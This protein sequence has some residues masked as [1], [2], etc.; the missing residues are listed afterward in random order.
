MADFLQTIGL[1]D[2]AFSRGIKRVVIN[3]R[4][5]GRD[6]TRAF[7]DA[8]KKLR[9]VGEQMEGI[10][11]AARTVSRAGVIVAASLAG[12]AVAGVQA[13]RSVSDQSDEARLAVERVDEATRRLTTTFGVLFAQ[14]GAGNAVARGLNA[15]G[16]SVQGVGIAL[17]ADDSARMATRGGA[18]QRANA[19]QLIQ[20]GQ[21]RLFELERERLRLSGQLTQLATIDANVAIGTLETELLNLLPRTE[22]GSQLGEKLRATQ[23]S[24]NRLNIARARQQEIGAGRRTAA[25]SGR[26]IALPSVSIE[27]GLSLSNRRQAFGGQ[28][29]SSQRAAQQTSQNT[30]K[31]ARLLGRIDDKLARG[32]PA[33]LS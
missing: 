21:D 3:A 1:D 7:D 9:S 32:L 2:A 17:G 30:A 28:S 22:F 29:Q 23:E 13:M 4:Q 20:A 6:M 14:S 24:I 18:L 15:L 10:G 16:E 8:D 27:T 19:S 33:V 25:A 12:T 11:K 31:S 26:T 5:A